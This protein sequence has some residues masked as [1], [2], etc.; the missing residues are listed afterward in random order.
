MKPEPYK[1]TPTF[2]QDTLPAAIRNAHN[3]KQGVWALLVVTS[4]EVRLVFDEPPRDVTVRPGEPGLIPP[5]EVHHVE[6]D[7]AMEMH[8]EFYRDKPLI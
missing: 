8:V 7:G 4:G 2:D 1:R 3:T 5:T 6:T